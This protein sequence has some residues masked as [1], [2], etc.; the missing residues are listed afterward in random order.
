MLQRLT[1]NKRV[2]ISFADK[3]EQ[4]FKTS[5]Y[6]VFQFFTMVNHEKLFYD[7][8][9]LCRYKNICYSIVRNNSKNSSHFKNKRFTKNFEIGKHQRSPSLLFQ[10]ERLFIF[11]RNSVFS[12]TSK[13]DCIFVSFSIL[14]LIYWL[15]YFL[16]G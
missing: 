15:I 2:E 9:K 12:F 10:L 4:P 16:S 3:N 5:Y 6:S 11:R 1:E 8:A 14:S 13:I 7:P